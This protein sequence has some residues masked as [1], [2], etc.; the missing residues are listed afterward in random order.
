[1]ELKELYKAL[2]DRVSFLERM[3][4]KAFE[5]LEMNIKT[6]ERLEHLLKEKEKDNG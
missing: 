5:L 2:E 6:F 3:N 1:M 4:I